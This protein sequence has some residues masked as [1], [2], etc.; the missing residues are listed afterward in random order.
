MRGPL[1]PLVVTLVIAAVI[2]A[3]LVWQPGTET[4]ARQLLVFCASGLQEPVAAVAEAYEKECG[5]AVQLQYG[6]SGTLLSN[7]QVAKQGDLYVAGDESYI[8]RARAQD[9]VDE[10]IPLA[11]MR[12]VLVVK[13]GNPAGVSSVRDLLRPEVRTALGNPGAAAVG[14]LARQLLTEAGVWAD[15]E[16]A[17]RSRGVFK[18]TVNEVANDVKLG[19]V[20]AGIVWDATANQYPELEALPLPGAETAGMHVTVGVLRAAKH[21]T[22]ALR[23]A[24]YLGARD[25][26]LEEFARGGFRPVEGDRW[27]EVPEITYFSGGVNRRG[28]EETIRAFE[29]REGVRITTVYNGCGILLGQI[30]LGEKPD[31]YHTCDATFMDGVEQRFAEPVPITETDIV[32]LV[33]KGNPLGIRSLTDC[34]KEGVRLGVANEEQSA[35]GALTANLLRERGIYDDVVKN[36]A[37]RTPT[38]DFLVSQI[39][40]GALDAAIVYEA[41]TTYTQEHLDLVRLDIDTAK[42][43][44]TFAVARDAKY[45]QLMGRLFDAIRSASSRG[46]FQKGGFRWLGPAEEP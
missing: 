25:R 38:A 5:V 18:P 24:R 36:V 13:Q 4:G 39:R 19:T 3:L 12:P 45:P 21:P 35:L 20:E 44:Q 43:V 2:V 11:T 1:V 14:K 46:R 37:V 9:L 31:V 23:F 40:T 16:K 33:A 10:A 6:G 8:N 28:I 30:K 29:E 15:V 27:A 41:N 7:L 34:G 22:A 17:V 42:A 26:G 32:I